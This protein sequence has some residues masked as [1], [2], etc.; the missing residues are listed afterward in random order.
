MDYA[1]S[2]DLAAA[3]W[4]GYLSFSFFAAHS[5]S[6]SWVVVQS[7]Q[8]RALGSFL[9]LF[10]YYMGSSLLG[11]SSGLIWENFGWNGLSLFMSVVL[12]LG[13]FFALKLRYGSSSYS[14][15]N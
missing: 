4:S 1:H 8:Y 5:T 6:S 12:M 11:S 10:S 3:V 14:T 13:L 7:L 9:Y 15:K 2:F